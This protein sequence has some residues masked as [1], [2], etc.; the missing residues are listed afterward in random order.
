MT[1]SYDNR[2]V[3]ISNKTAKAVALTAA[4]IA[5]F[6]LKAPFLIALL[7]LL[8][9]GTLYVLF[10]YPIILHVKR[11]A[12]RQIDRLV[13]DVSKIE[14]RDAM[15]LHANFSELKWQSERIAGKI[16]AFF[17]FRPVLKQ[18][19][20]LA[21]AYRL[22]E[23]AFAERAYP[24]KYKMDNEQAGKLA[25]IFKDWGEDWEDEKMEVYNDN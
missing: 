8:V 14:Q 12:I 7:L 10:T 3:D 9:F 5:E 24:E 20:D 17:V 21:A 2:T 1:I 18:F 11:K 4:N 25:E 16:N 22:A 6:I 23:D 15:I 19:T 13:Q